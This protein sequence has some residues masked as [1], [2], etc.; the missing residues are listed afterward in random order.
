MMI[1]TTTVTLEISAV[2]DLNGTDKEDLEAHLRASLNKAISGGLITGLSNTELLMYSANVTVDRHDM[3][4]EVTSFLNA[5]IAD[6]NL[7]AEGMGRRLARYGLQ[8]PADFLD[9]IEERS[10]VALEDAEA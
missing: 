3:E 6:G 2:L 1:I 4:D 8:M 9:E 7:D 5:Q 10:S